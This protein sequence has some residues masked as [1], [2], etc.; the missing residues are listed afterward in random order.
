MTVWIKKIK[1]VI[2]GSEN[3]LNALH[4]KG[5]LHIKNGKIFV[6]STDD[7]V[8]QLYELDRW[9]KS[10]ENE[11]QKAQELESKLKHL[12]LSIELRG[13]VESIEDVDETVDAVEGDG[14]KISKPIRDA[15][16][17]FQKGHLVDLP[18]DV[19]GRFLKK[20]KENTRDEI[21]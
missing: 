20:S 17:C 18:R 19:H 10:Y 9:K 14:I 1:E 8:D 6:L 5:L 7:I 16:G 21:K 11:K 4:E 13:L 15:K 3:S 2:V 12:E